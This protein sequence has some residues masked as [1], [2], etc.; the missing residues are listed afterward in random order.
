[1]KKLLIVIL[2]LVTLSA[3]AQSNQN[4]VKKP[5][6]IISIGLVYLILLLQILLEGA[7]TIEQVPK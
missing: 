1:M 4:K 7:G 2:T 6:Y 3:L 5:K